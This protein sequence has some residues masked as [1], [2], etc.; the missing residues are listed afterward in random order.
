MVCSYCASHNVNGDVSEF[1]SGN[2]LLQSK[3]HFDIIFLD[4]EM[5]GMDGIETAKKYKELHRNTLI[6]VVTAYQKYLDEAMD[7][8]V[9]RYI[10]KPV[11]QKRI[12]DGLD[13]AIGFLNHNTITFKTKESGIITMRMS[14]IL[15]VEVVHRNAC[16]VTENNKYLTREKMDYFKSHLT[17]TY[18]VIPHN[19]YI[20]NLNYVIQFK[21]NCIQ[22]S[23]KEIISI[24]PKKQVEIKKDFMRFMGENNGSLSDD[25]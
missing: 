5:E 23:N 4:I 11:N 10:D 6:F 13:K 20:V 12:F 16:V 9:F 15:Y 25:F 3:E 14:D 2:A 22:M 21:R 19:S 17:A 18:F 8:H 1:L 24:A 7:L